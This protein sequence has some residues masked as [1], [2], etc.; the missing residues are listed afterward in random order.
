MIHINTYHTYDVYG[1][2]STY[3]GDV[4]VQVDLQIPTAWWTKILELRQA[5]ADCSQKRGEAGWTWC[6]G[7]EQWGIKPLLDGQ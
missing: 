3:S 2:D 4:I 6:S 7:A 1:T 5:T